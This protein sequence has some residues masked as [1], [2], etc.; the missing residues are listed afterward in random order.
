MKKKKIFKTLSPV[1][2]GSTVAFL[3]ASCSTNDNTNTQKQYTMSE[4]QKQSYQAAQQFFDSKKENYFSALEKNVL[5]SYKTQELQASFNNDLFSFVDTYEKIL[6]TDIA[7]PYSGVEVSSSELKDDLINKNLKKF[8]DLVRGETFSVDAFNSSL[9]QE[10]K[11]TEKTIENR[12]KLVENKNRELDNF[13][14]SLSKLELKNPNILVVANNDVINLWKAN[15]IFSVVEADKSLSE[16]VNLVDL[17][18]PKQNE[19]ISKVVSKVKVF[20]ANYTTEKNV[21]S[22]K[23]KID[24]LIQEFNSVIKAQDLVSDYLKNKIS[25]FKEQIQADKE[26]TEEQIQSILAETE[27]VSSELQL[28]NLQSKVENIKSGFENLKKELVAEIENTAII[29][30][31]KDRLVFKTMSFD[32]LT[33]FNEFKQTFSDLKNTLNSLIEADKE[34]EQKREAKELKAAAEYDLYKKR[35][36]FKPI[37]KNFELTEL[38]LTNFDFTK[39]KIQEFKQKLQEVSDLNSQSSSDQ[40]TVVDLFKEETQG[41]W[42]VDFSQNALAYDIDK[43]SYSASFN[44]KNAKVIFD[45]HDTAIVDFEIIDLQLDKENWNKLNI[46]TKATLKNNPEVFYII[47]SSKIFTKDVSEYTKN[48]NFNNLDQI[49]DVDY[50]TLAE[51]KEEEFNALSYKEKL[52][53]FK[54]RNKAVNNFFKFKLEDDFEIRTNRV[55]A[56]FSVF[57]NNQMLSSAKIP[58]IRKVEFVEAGVDKEKFMDRLNENK[59]LEI[60]NGDS[61][62]FFSLLKF[63]EGVKESHAQYLSSDAIEVVNKL[64]EWPKFGKY[65]IF[66]KEITNKDVYN[67]WADLV[68]WYKKDGKEAEIKDLADL[69]SKAK[70]LHSFKLTSLDDIKPKNGEFFTAEDFQT[71]TPI[72]ARW[73]GILNT[74]N[75]SNIILR[76]TMPEGNVDQRTIRVHDVDDIIEQKA[77]I[78]MNY[79]FQI[80]NGVEDGRTDTNYDDQVYVPSD[81]KIY[82]KNVNRNVIASNNFNDIMNNFFFYFYDVKKI[83]KRGISFKLG[84]INK[85]DT[86]IRYASSNEITLINLVNDYKQIHYPRIMVNKLS[87]SNLTINK[88]ELAKHDANYFATHLDELNSLI[89]ININGA[90]ANWEYKHFSLPKSYFKVAS[91]KR[92]SGTQAFVRFSVQNKDGQQTLADKWIKINGFAPAESDFP[93]QSL[94]FDTKEL[95]VVQES[96]TEITRERVIEPYWRDLFWSLDKQTNVAS[97][98]L[99]KKYLA[100]TLLKPNAKNRTLKLNILANVLKNDSQ[101]SSRV[102][103]IN[104]SISLEVNFE[105]LIS[106]KEKVFK[107]EME[108]GENSF[109]YFIKLT[110]NEQK[111][112]EF[113]ISMEDDSYKIVVGEPEVQKYES[114]QEFD[115]QRAFL[116]LPAAVKTT[117]VYTNDEE[118]EDFGLKNPTNR[119]QYNEMLYNEFE[120]PLLFSSDTEYLADKEHYN[121]N[122]NVIYKLHDGYKM[123]IDHI[124]I[125]QQRDWDIV[126]TAFSRN[127]LIT[128]YGTTATATFLGKVNDDPEDATFYISTNWHTHGREDFFILNKPEDWKFSQFLS[129]VYG[130]KYGFSPETVSNS[131]DR[132]YFSR[133]HR[134]YMLE[135]V[136]IKLIWSGVDRRPNA[137]GQVARTERDRDWSIFSADVTKI[138]QQYRSEG[139]ME[140]VLRMENL[141]KKS[142]IKFD[143]PYWVGQIDVPNTREASTLGWALAKYTGHINRRPQTSGHVAIEQWRQQNFLSSPFLGPGS[144]GSGVFVD[145]D[146]YYGIWTS[147]AKYIFATDYR[148]D[149]R[150]F[151]YFGI[152]WNGE[153]PLELKN[154][155]SAGAY[156][157]KAN[158]LHPEKYDLPW[159]W[160]EIK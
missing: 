20:L 27:N 152:N 55:Y 111:G 52:K 11:E 140:V 45:V 100:S 150:D 67:G 10:I 62:K 96:E 81:A 38:D 139:N 149:N 19:E 24:Q 50:K 8:D 125:K 68:L 110:W 115:K 70:R 28:Q 74:I 122:Q 51:Y 138:I 35:I 84:I 156:I 77:F 63:K 21:S 22:L 98:T 137:Q 12:N 54:A 90:D 106:K 124:R 43:F 117:V 126:D 134:Q 31:F 154:T 130:R 3:A 99:D 30:K 88:T 85:R 7:K 119:F 76:K 64:Y 79:L 92:V 34:L 47:N 48:L 14:D 72:D 123:N 36:G 97:W 6:K 75:E 112:L 135:G 39:G 15:A 83:G 53:F 113:E 146:T 142:N 104:N 143:Q 1:L 25:A 5:N 121:P 41:L 160:K 80:V 116:V 103:N 118:Q 78:K 158:L 114:N 18:E 157:T 37:Y 33:K 9:V 49:F 82:S 128:G 17:Y 147:G 42:N 148:Y 102:R 66:I 73:S 144:S 95:M 159:F 94:D 107:R 29:S 151:N 65:E 108:N 57:F 60:I 120:M 26:L 46:T 155:E 13:I 133:Q 87:L 32:D 69:R 131:V 89:N 101:K 86:S 91:V 71:A 56:T 44:F 132:G 105:E 16:L 109:N 129:S 136:E 93:R 4:E 141:L 153:N 23:Q 59:V 61:S 2:F 145:N 127:V 40:K 58:T